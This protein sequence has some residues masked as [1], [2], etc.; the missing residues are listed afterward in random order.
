MKKMKKIIAL[1][2]MV[3]SLFAV[4][5]PALAASYKTVNAYPNVNFWSTT[6]ETSLIDRIPFGATV[7]EQWTTTVGG[8]QYSYI[9]YNSTYGY[10]RTLYLGAGTSSRP[11]TKDQ[12]FGTYDIKQ[13][14]N[15]SYYVKNVQLC[16]QQLGYYL[17]PKGADGYFGDYT[18]GALLNLQDVNGL[19]ADGI[20]GNRT[21][22]F[23][24][25]N[26]SNYLMN[27]GVTQ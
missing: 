15:Y 10:V 17:G 8:V 25:N 14:N 12:A 20:I 3:L 19:G 21:K 1:A 23:L 11:Q 2:L 9:K 7:E 5:L 22:T 13:N 4:A 27:N 26:Y 16:L 18:M 6:S 24:W